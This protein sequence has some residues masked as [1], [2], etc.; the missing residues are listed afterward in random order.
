MPTADLRKQVQAMAGFGLP[1]EKI[2]RIV[3]VSQPTLRK[4]YR[5]ELDL[6]ADKANSLVADSLFKKAL[7]NGPSSVTAAIFWLKTRAG[8]K[9]TVVQEHGSDPNKPLIHRVE[10]LIIDPKPQSEGA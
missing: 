4:H 6:G 3:G 8:W 7:A 5:D 9:E 10:R 2:A 1:Q